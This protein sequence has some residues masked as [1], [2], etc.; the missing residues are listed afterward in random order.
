MHYGMCWGC[1]PARQQVCLALGVGVV[2]EEQVLEN[3]NGHRL[4]AYNTVGT[5]WQRRVC[6]MGISTTVCSGCLDPWSP[7]WWHSEG[8]DGP[9]AGGYQ[10]QKRGALTHIGH[11]MPRCLTVQPQPLA[12]FFTL[13]VRGLGTRLEHVGELFVRLLCELP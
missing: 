5:G 12:V 11:C 2:E 1:D 8:Q 4:V 6:S 10:E 13:E 3:P 7:L 9:T